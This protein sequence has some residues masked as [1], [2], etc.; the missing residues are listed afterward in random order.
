MKNNTAKK[1]LLAGAL[2]ALCAGATPVA[3]ATTAASVAA[4]FTTVAPPILKLL[5]RCALMVGYFL[6]VAGVLQM[7]RVED[8]KATV[9]QVAWTLFSAGL[10]VSM[11]TWMAAV[12]QTFGIS[13][14][15]ASANILAGAI[16]SPGGSGPQC[17]AFGG[18]LNFVR[19]VGLIAFIRGVLI[20]KGH[21]EGDKNA[22]LGR[23]ATHIGGGVAAMNII[24]T[25]QTMASTFGATALL[26]VMCIG[27]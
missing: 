13:G 22:S 3:A 11:G 27:G 8:G 15:A 26:S 18:I 7:T 1:M 16:V 21:G 6:V 12:E 17:G 9:K 23:A 5:A 14:S 20:L 19:V 4:Q 10:L 2:L 25:A 24:W